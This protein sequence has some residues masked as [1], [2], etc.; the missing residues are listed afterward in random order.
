MMAAQQRRN[1]VTG[2]ETNSREGKS[3]ASQS[4]LK[5]ARGSDFEINGRSHLED[6][7]TNDTR[8][9]SLKTKT[10]PCTKIEDSEVRKSIDKDILNSDAKLEMEIR[11]PLQPPIIRHSSSP[12][13]TQDERN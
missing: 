11:N 1:N 8:G 12:M 6:A 2:S 5:S 7:K 3:Y 4:T 10:N 13:K 9:I